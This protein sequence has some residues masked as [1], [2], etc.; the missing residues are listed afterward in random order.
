M[1]ENKTILPTALS[2]EVSPLYLGKI[3]FLYATASELSH[4]EAQNFNDSFKA[5]ICA[6]R[7]S[8]YPESLV[9]F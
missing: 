8:K 5:R 3:L 6:S 4:K 7:S 2:A 9:S 1:L